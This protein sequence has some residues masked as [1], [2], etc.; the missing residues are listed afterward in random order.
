MTTY[1]IGV[2]DSDGNDCSVFKALVTA[3]GQ[4]AAL[5]RVCAYVEKAYPKDEWDGGYGTYHPCNCACEHRKRSVCARC[6]D[7]WECSHGGILIDDVNVE[8][9]ATV[10]EAMGARARYHGLI[11]LT[12]PE[13]VS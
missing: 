8:E 13:P 2:L 5:A 11:D 10:E 6:R 1:L 3:E 7:E 12:V 9:Y 4:E